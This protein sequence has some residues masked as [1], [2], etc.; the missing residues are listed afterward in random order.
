MSFVSVVPAH[1]L[2]VLGLGGTIILMGRWDVDVL[3]DV[4]QQERAT[5]TYVPSPLLNDFARVV[6]ERPGAIASLNS[7]VHSASR[8]APEAVA[9]VLKAVGGSRYIDAWGMTEHSGAA[10]TA[11]VPEDYVSAGSRDM[12][13]SVGR[14]TI[15]AAVRV[16]DP[17]TCEELDW[18]GETVG[19]LVVSSPALMTGYW[20]RPEATAA[21]FVD[22]WYRTGDLGTIDADGFVA[23]AE[24][25]T[26]LIV[27]GGMNVYPGEVEACIGR[28]AGVREVAVVGVPHERWGQS[29]LAA[30]VLEPNASVA[31]DD[32]LAICHDQLAGFKKPSRIVFVDELP[33]TTSLKV[34]R[35]VLRERMTELVLSANS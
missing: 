8:G 26:D 32:V 22:G 16:V 10:V 25:R 27:S 28:L 7:V 31:P 18:D 14:A 3:L 9:A 19:E 15:D 6:L 2:C 21:A 35:T 24:R 17:E 4:I 29:V 20:K 5:F 13:Q 23:I 11:T 1:I 30:I 12:T 34:A 33:R